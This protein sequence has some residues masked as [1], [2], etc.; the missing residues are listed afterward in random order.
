MPILKEHRGIHWIHAVSALVLLATGVILYSQSLSI[1]LGK[2]DDFRL[3][4]LLASVFF[5]LPLMFGGKDLSVVYRARRIDLDNFSLLFTFYFI[6]WFSITGVMILLN[7]FSPTA[8]GESVLF[9]HLLLTLPF[10]PFLIAHV[11]NNYKLID[12]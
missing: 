3:L 4:H 7:E 1:L 11:V 9:I 5:L 10:I 6:I 2:R 12:V 8:F